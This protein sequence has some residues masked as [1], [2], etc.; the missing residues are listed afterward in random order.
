M[1]CSCNDNNETVT[2]C[3]TP[4]SQPIIPYQCITRTALERIVENYNQLFPE[5]TIDSKQLNADELYLKVQQVMKEKFGCEEEVCWVQSVGNDMG[6]K[7]SLL[8]LLPPIMPQSFRDNS[9]LWWNNRQIDEVM[10]RYTYSAPFYW[11]GAVPLDFKQQRMI[12][13]CLTREACAVDIRKVVDAGCCLIGVVFNLDPS[14][15]PGSHW[16]CAAVDLRKGDICFFDSYGYKPLT[17][18]QEW[19]MNCA[20]GLNELIKDDIWEP[21]ED[22][23]LQLA[24]TIL[25]W[26]NRRTVDIGLEHIPRRL[27]IQDGQFMISKIT[28]HKYC[29]KAYDTTQKR[30]VLDKD[31]TEEEID[32]DWSILGAR[33]YVSS[34]KCQTSGGECGTFCIYVLLQFLKGKDWYD[35][36]RDIPSQRQIGGL[37]QK[38]YRMV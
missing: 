20:N 1:S 14:D 30:V 7:Q 6:T 37:R 17:F 22:K 26:K 8:Q 27:K 19:M 38:L 16:V 21:C 12:D 5:D 34:K 23:Q 4:D 2:V 33:L 10:R 3:V 13:V 29:I 24:S 18:I 15:L 35:I 31:V 9:K 28:N 36:L 11:C 25:T 32:G